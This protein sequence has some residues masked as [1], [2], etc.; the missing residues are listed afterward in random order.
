MGRTKQT[1]R[2]STGGKAPRKMLATTTAHKKPPPAFT[3]FN[4]S[5]RFEYSYCFISVHLSLATLRGVCAYR[6]YFYFNFPWSYSSAVY[7]LYVFMSKFGFFYSTNYPYLGLV[8]SLTKAHIKYPL[9]H[10]KENEKG[11]RTF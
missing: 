3:P 10:M 2:A 6:L 9:V 5:T 1:A 4:K 7:V 8:C 11:K